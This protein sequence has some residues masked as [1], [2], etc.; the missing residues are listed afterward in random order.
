MTADSVQR[1][2][3]TTFKRDADRELLGFM[4]EDRHVRWLTGEELLSRSVA[5]A[6]ELGGAG[7]VRGTVCPIVLP[8]GEHAA[9]SVLACLLQGAVPLN[10]APPMLQAGSENL[11]RILDFTLKKTGATTVIC[12]RTLQATSDLGSVC[13]TVSPSDAPAACLTADFSPALPAADDVAAMQLT[14]GT[15]GLPKICVWR[16]QAVN[17]ALDGMAAAMEL[18]RRD[19]CLNW[20]P[21][22]HDMGLVNNFLLCMTYGVPLVL[23]D[24]HSFVK[25]P[26]LWLQGLS[27]TRATLSWSPN[28]GY[29][30][31][32]QR[33]M[34]A[35]LADL[36]LGHVRGLWNAAEKIHF[37]TMREF[38]GRF[39]G[40]G[41]KRSA[42]RTNYGLAENIG[43]ATFSH[44]DFEEAVEYVDR[45]ALQEDR[46]ARSVSAA[47]ECAI[48]VVNAGTPHPQLT[49][50][51]LSESGELLPEGCVGEI[52]LRSPS[53]MS[54]YLGAGEKEADTQSETLRTGDLG[55]LRR[56]D[57]YWVGRT[58]ERI[59]VCGKK[60]D[61]SDFE[62]AINQT[63]G[64]RAGN[65]AAFGVPDADRGT[66]SI[67]VVAEL[68]DAPDTETV[69]ADLRRRIFQTLGL[70]VSEVVL[71]ERGVLTKTSSGK[72]R[73]C[74]FREMY[75]SGQLKSHFERR[76][77]A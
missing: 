23:L 25:R 46:I 12:D 57:L 51:I 7:V 36:T 16:Q 69:T 75:L 67:V 40:C 50:E 37:R 77:A 35:D 62:L 42:L 30:L 48:E 14:S 54:H 18:T 74:H 76:R 20:T 32:A 5:L 68:R 28:F 2:I 13:R 27:D 49:V 17:A 29:A 8:S 70:H 47:D 58:R 64:L 10:L 63:P 66:E 41:L 34:D 55:Y 38:Y 71:V 65:F 26:G 44:C 21:L 3:L 56:G 43:G 60:I 39:S 1:R 31:A 72:R 6:K 22:Y 24:P 45:H 61:P 59:T 33:T 4:G 9:L 19:V 53:R 15:T 11:T 73:H 52:G